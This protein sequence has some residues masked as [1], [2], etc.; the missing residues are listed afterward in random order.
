MGLEEALD[1]RRDAAGLQRQ[2]WNKSFGVP[3]MARS[4]IGTRERMACVQACSVTSLKRCHPTAYDL[5][6]KIACFRIKQDKYTE[7][8]KELNVAR[9]QEKVYPVLQKFSEIESDPSNED[10]SF[11]VHAYKALICITGEETG[12]ENVSDPGAVKERQYASSY[13]DDNVNSAPSTRIRKRI[14]NGSRRFL[15]DLF[16]SQLEA[17]VSRNSREANIG[18]VPTAIAKVKGYVR[19]RASRRELGQDTDVL[20]QVNG[21]YCWP[22]IF[23]MLRSGL[24]QQALEYVE[25]NTGAFRQIDRPFM[26]Y[27]RA[28][29][30]SEDHRL[31]GDMQTSINNEY[32]Q[33]SRLAP[34]DS[35]DP[36]RMVCYKIIGRCELT[37]RNTGWH[38]KRYDGLDLAAVCVS[39]RVQPSR[40]VRARS[41]WS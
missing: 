29:V 35:I 4:V 12:I 6:Q 34:E 20:Q 26:R 15:E 5:L 32:S 19:V 18:G 13:L 39:T 28:Y 17:T 10:T 36:Y 14:I 8:V 27:L 9:L 30:T 1:D 2:R 40:R 33:R 24:Y 25:E 16:F 11:L 31:P 41:V 23:Y 37:K 22:V 3:G 7:R 38:Y 21:D